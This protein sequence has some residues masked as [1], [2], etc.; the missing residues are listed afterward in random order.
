MGKRACE[1]PSGQKNCRNVDLCK[2]RGSNPTKKGPQRRPRGKSLSEYRPVQIAG[3]QSVVISTCAT[4]SVEQVAFSTGFS[5]PRPPRRTIRGAIC[6]NIDLCKSFSCTS[7]VFDR[8][9]FS[10]SSRRPALSGPRPA[11]PRLARTAQSVPSRLCRLARTAP[12]LPPRPN[13]P[14]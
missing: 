8:I 13:R 7:R 11:L 6:R 3:A 9:F 5:L 12:P 2:S 4:L 1:T 14:A 10:R